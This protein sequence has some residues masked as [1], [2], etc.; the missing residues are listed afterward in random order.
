MLSSPSTRRARVTP[1]LT[2]SPSSWGALPMHPRPTFWSH[3]TANLTSDQL[4]TRLAWWEDLSSLSPLH[5]FPV[6]SWPG[7]VWSVA[8]LWALRILPRGSFGAAGNGKSQWD[9]PHLFSAFGSR[10]CFSDPAR[11]PWGC[12]RL[13]SETSNRQR[14]L[15]I[16]KSA[17]LRFPCFIFLVGRP[18]PTG[19]A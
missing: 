5:P 10:C 9:R 15:S 11:C 19:T 4:V 16:A 13:H 8:L 6:F 3:A 14:Q 18:S 1:T 12:C 17:P 7:R 2:N